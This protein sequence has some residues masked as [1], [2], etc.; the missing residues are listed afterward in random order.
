MT[1][2]DPLYPLQE[3]ANELQAAALHKVRIAA[4]RPG[5][6]RSPERATAPPPG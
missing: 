2:P 5:S 1:D 4:R 3:F 6:R